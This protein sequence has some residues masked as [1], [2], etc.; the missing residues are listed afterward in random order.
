M[1]HNLLFVLAFFRF[2]ANEEKRNLWIAA[3]GR[4][5][6][7][8]TKFSHICSDHF[9]SADYKVPP[10]EPRPRLT[11]SAVPSIF[12]D[13]LECMRRK[14]LKKRRQI[15]SEQSDLSIMKKETERSEP[16]PNSP[17]QLTIE[18]PKKRQQLLTEQPNLNIRQ[19]ENEQRESVSSSPKQLLTEPSRKTEHLIAEQSNTKIMRVED[20][21]S[22]SV[23]TLDPNSLLIKK[24]RKKIKVLHQKVRRRDRR[25]KALR[26]YVNG[27][28]RKTVLSQSSTGLKDN[29][30]SPFVELFLAEFKNGPENL[31]GG[32]AQMN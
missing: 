22:E 29:F 7:H 12:P 16:V 10:G 26:E 2:P 1:I 25:L 17:K 27:V 28:K 6:W 32:G 24:L 8:P 23:P 18:S 11:P 14:S 31:L 21:N 19:E 30:S 15:V 4:W 13:S 9:Y 5:K 3:V 20:Q